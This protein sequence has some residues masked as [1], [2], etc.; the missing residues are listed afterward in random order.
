METYCEAYKVF[1]DRSKTERECVST[2]I[3]LAEN[4]GFRPWDPKQ[5][6]KPGD[7]VYFSNRGKAIMLAVVGRESAS[8]GVN[9]AVAHTDAPRLDLKPRPLYE[10]GEMAYFKTHY[11]GG[12]L[13]YQ[14]VATPLVLHGV[15]VRGDG[16]SVN[17]RIGDDPGDPQFVG[18]ILLLDHGICFNQLKNLP[19][20]LGHNTTS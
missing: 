18:N 2:A 4:A 9:I 16:T 13:K 3:E 20:P 6:L 7:R 10:D 15:V 8:Q 11:Y 12:I 1:L 19:F 17:V 14:W 5:T